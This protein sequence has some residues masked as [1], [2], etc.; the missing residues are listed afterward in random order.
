MPK[1]FPTVV[2]AVA[3][4]DLVVT[5]LLVW[6]GIATEFLELLYR[7]NAFLGGDATSPGFHT[8]HELF[9]SLAGV[10]GV[11]WALARILDPRPLLAGLDAIGRFVVAAMM[12]F[13]V[14][15]G[16]APAILFVF[17]GTELAGAIWQGVALLS[18]M[19]S[20]PTRP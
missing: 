8:I 19:T 17:V 11:L 13:A 9:V 4:F 2:R 16:Q 20:P 6:P 7:V 15:G 18:E 10:L 12:V 14:L 5:G 1:R 3:A